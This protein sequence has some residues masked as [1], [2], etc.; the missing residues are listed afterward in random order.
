MSFFLKWVLP[1]ILYFIAFSIMDMGFF[2]ELFVAFL[3][4]GGVISYDIGRDME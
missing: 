2:K 1:F 3:I 4:Q